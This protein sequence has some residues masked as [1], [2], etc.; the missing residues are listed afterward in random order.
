MIPFHE[1]GKWWVMDAE[2]KQ[3][4][5]L[6]KFLQGWELL[7]HSG[8]YP[9]TLFGEWNGEQLLPLSVWIENQFFH[10]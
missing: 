10:L 1:N 7:A 2:K 3:L 5:V 6:A 9:I 8:G 4:S